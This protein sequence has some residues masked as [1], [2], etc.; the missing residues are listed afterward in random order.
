MNKWHFFTFFLLLTGTAMASIDASHVCEVQ[1]CMEGTG[2]NFTIQIY[3]NLKY[4]ITADD[5]Y[6]KDVDTKQVLAVDVRKERIILPLTWQNFTLPADIQA[7]LNGYTFYYVPCFRAKAFNASEV[8]GEKEVC[9]SNIQSLTVLPLAKMECRTDA[10]C[11]PEQYCKTSS[12]YKCK[13]LECRDDQKIVDHKCVDLQCNSLQY[14]K[15]NSCVYNQ[16]LLFGFGI[17]MIIVAVIAFLSYNSLKPKRKK[18]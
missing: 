6:I 3:N 2:V 11:K 18:R 13:P 15:Q 4:P 10:E 16:S 12:L 8:L 9:S 7:P 1:S 14:P 17:F 5:L